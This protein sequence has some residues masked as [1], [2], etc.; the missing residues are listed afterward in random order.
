M[1]FKIEIKNE[2]KVAMRLREIA[3]KN[4][5]FAKRFRRDVA[6]RLTKSLKSGVIESG[7]VFTTELLQGIKTRSSPPNSWIVTIPGHG[8]FIN[9]GVTPHWI[10]RDMVSSTG[11]RVG[12]WMD[13]KG[14]KGNF[15]LVGNS[16]P[17]KKPGTR[18]IDRAVSETRFFARSKAQRYQ[19]EV[20]A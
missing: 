14:I 5:D 17:L 19:Q 20:L 7:A 9:E 1:V 15:M 3:K 16:G 6:T 8:K 18:F 13:A 10:H 4:E 11:I 12:D 2:K